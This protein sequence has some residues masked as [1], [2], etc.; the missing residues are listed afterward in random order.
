[1]KKILLVEEEDVMVTAIEFRLQK[2]G[3]Q[4][5]KAKNADAAQHI[6]QMDTPDLAIVSLNLQNGAGMDLVKWIRKEM[7]AKLPVVIISE[8]EQEEEVM[9]AYDAGANDFITKPFK[10]TE[11]VLRVMHL[12]D[13]YETK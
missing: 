3:C 6:L 5:S 11:L 4:V 9:E 10:P 1:M 7:G 8:L 2:I 12:L 13:K